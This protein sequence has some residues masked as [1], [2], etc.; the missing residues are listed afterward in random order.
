MITF[1]SFVKIALISLACPNKPG[2][3]DLQHLVLST[4]A[5][6]ISSHMFCTFF[7]MWGEFHLKNPKMY[8]APTIHQ[9]LTQIREKQFI[10]SSACFSCLTAHAGCDKCFLAVVI[11][12]IFPITTCTSVHKYKGWLL[13]CV[14]PY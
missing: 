8:I 9:R 1:T 7:L 11:N 14:F 13:A 3:G 2:S 6:F 5:T 12:I 10:Y 4:E